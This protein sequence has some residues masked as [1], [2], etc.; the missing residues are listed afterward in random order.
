MGEQT[1]TIFGEEIPVDYQEISIYELKYFEENP[2]VFSCVF[3]ENK[4]EDDD[5]LQ[6]FIQEKMWQQPSVKKLIP[7]IMEHD[8]L[9]ESILIRYDTKHVI[10]GNSRLAVF[11]HL[12]KTTKADKWSTIPCYCVSGLT[13][14]QQDA[15][16]SQIHI[17]GKT[18]WSAYEKA[19]F[20]YIRYKK[21]VSIEEISHRTS[22]TKN[23]I[24]KRITI[25]DSMQENND[26]EQSHFSYYDVLERTRNIK[27][28]KNYTDDVKKYLL[29]KI[30]NI[31][32][33]D[34]NDVAFTAQHL[35]DKF[36]DVLRKKKELK[37]FMAGESTLDEAYHN[38][39]PSDPL[40]KVKT[41]KDKIT[42]ISKREIDRLEKQEV[43]A[44]F[45]NIK[46]L[47]KEV[48]RIHSMAEKVK[49]ENQQNAQ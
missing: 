9:L 39:R 43:D 21:D 45:V 32:V 3:G 49:K 41:A 27:Q 14:Q 28:E 11:R 24:G 34:S 8:G 47:S 42:D 20:S 29:S 18:P 13:E 46:K 10:E 4:P 2:R 6:E 23:E 17:K 31:G 12:H 48:N 16:L 5:K 36:P 22:E 1:I 15:Y 7:T 33:E 26:E 38:A 37:K 40:Q 44:L 30:K 25:I 19:N 35:R